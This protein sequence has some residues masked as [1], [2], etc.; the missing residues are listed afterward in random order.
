MSEGGT[1]GAEAGAEAE[2]AEVVA[3]TEAE[4]AAEGTVA[5]AEAGAAKTVA[6][7]VGGARA[8]DAVRARRAAEPE[9][10]WAVLDS[11]TEEGVDGAVGLE[12]SWRRH[13]R[14]LP[15]LWEWLDLGAMVSCSLSWE[16]RVVGRAGG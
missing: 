4:G 12:V 15:C 2:E 11:S 16:M 3:A 13:S 14:H 9:P 7:A 8:D 6:A 1:A 5:E 10:W